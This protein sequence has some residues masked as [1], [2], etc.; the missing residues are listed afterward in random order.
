M[1][2]TVGGRTSC[3]PRPQNQDWLHWDLDTGLLVVADGMGG[4]NA[5]EVAAHLAIEAMTRFIRHSRDWANVTWPFGF[6]PS[7]SA[8]V[9]RLQ[10]AVR[11]ANRRVCA[12]GAAHAA[13]NGMG[14]TV[15][16]ALVAGDT[17]GLVSVGDSRIYRWRGGRLVQ[18]TDDDTWLAAMA[19]AGIEPDAVGSQHPMRHVLTAVV[20][21]TEDLP[22]VVIEERLEAGDRLVLCSDGVHGC[23]TAEVLAQLIG[24]AASSEAAARALVDAA[25]AAGTSDNATALVAIA[26]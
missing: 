25:L 4:H 23:L 12:E 13:F 17:V 7:R 5:G 9:N 2:V 21:A 15:V 26:L 14:T 3:G 19:R 18:L 1:Q 6:D 10:T 8:V 20:G 24:E 11:L 16:A 22:L